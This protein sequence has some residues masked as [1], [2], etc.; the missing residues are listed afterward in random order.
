MNDELEQFDE[1]LAAIRQ[2]LVGI[3]ENDSPSE[4]QV[5]RSEELLAEW[6]TVTA[7]RAACEER[8]ESARV[9]A[10]RVEAIRNAPVKES[11]FHAP[12][13]ISRRS[14]FDGIE[15]VNRRGLSADEMR[16]RALTAIENTRAAGVSD[17]AKENATRMA[18]MDESVTGEISR[19]FL[20]TGSPSYRSAF[21]VILKHPTDFGVRLSA[22]QAEAFR[23][24]MSTTNA[25]GGYA[26]PFLLD[27]TIILT[28]TGSQNPFRRIATI[29][30]GTS[31]K[32]QG[33][34]SAGVSFSWVAENTALSDGSPTLGQPSITAHKA[35]AWISASFEVVQDTN[36]AAELPALLADGKDRGEASAFAIGSGSG[37]PYGVVTAVA[38]VT[39]S[40]VSPTT[41]G[42]FTENSVAD[43]YKVADAL[44][45]VHQENAAWVANHKVYSLIRQMSP[46]AAGSSFWANLGVGTPQELL[47]AP[48]YKAVA[49]D[50]TMTTGAEAIVI[51]DF[52]NY[53]IY[54][55]IGMGI[56]YIP[57]QVDGSGAPLL[58][59][60]WVAH[61]RVGADVVN[62]DAFRVLQL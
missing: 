6:D 20:L 25:N 49:M 1:R 10:E 42:V 14:P 44:P 31:N 26:I 28:S 29:K 24:A 43:V 23:T 32:W 19:H 59:R 51:G 41:G 53:Y 7:E 56:E 27:P 52:K 2:E 21:E 46:S 33:L 62:A 17:Q 12:N 38:A 13:V 40:R 8:I 16:A 30:T 35:A 4:E 34:T 48:A 18:E 54:D 15:E 60:G 22:E 36:I 5:T 50:S 58:Q 55:R 57:S 11:G 47:G 61:W 37:A 9:H 45:D 3:E 39:A